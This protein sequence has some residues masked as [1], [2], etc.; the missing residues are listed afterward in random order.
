[1]NIIDDSACDVQKRNLA[2]E[3]IGAIAGRVYNSEHSE[4]EDHE[5]ADS[6]DA[7]ESNYLIR[8]DVSFSST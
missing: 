6:D 7:D 1:M 4:T 3:F 5:H 2:T 8:G